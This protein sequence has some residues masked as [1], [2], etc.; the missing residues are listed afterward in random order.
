M[1]IIIISAQIM[2]IRHSAQFLIQAYAGCPEEKVLNTRENLELIS[3]VLNA[4]FHQLADS[5][6]S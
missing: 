3:I 2:K 5:S 1:I 6:N 4:G